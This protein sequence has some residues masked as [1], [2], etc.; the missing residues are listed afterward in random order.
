MAVDWHPEGDPPSWEEEVEPP[1]FEEVTYPGQ[2][3]FKRPPERLV[4]G[5]VAWCPVCRGSGKREKKKC[6][7]CSGYGYI[8][9]VGPI[10]SQPK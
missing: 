4:F 10:A 6:R 1:S 2:T 5:E 9:N 3:A 7:R 8:P